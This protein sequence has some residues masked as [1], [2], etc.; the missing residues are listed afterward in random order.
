MGEN[1]RFHGKL[2]ELNPL[3]LA[4]YIYGKQPLKLKPQEIILHGGPKPVQDTKRLNYGNTTLQRTTDI[5]HRAWATSRSS[6][7]IKIGVNKNGS[8][9]L[10]FID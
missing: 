9:Q 5:A 10:I 3:T 8:N 2:R 4:R 6:Q 7:S 1:M